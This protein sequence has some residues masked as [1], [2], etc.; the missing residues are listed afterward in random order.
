MPIY[1]TFYFL[2]LR[3]Y[4]HSYPISLKY[5][6]LICYIQL[7]RQLYKNFR[8]HD[9]LWISRINLVLRQIWGLPGLIEGDFF[10]Q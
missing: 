2:I 1:K 3:L 7:K 6:E 8:A 5:L 10:T 9:T 4:Y